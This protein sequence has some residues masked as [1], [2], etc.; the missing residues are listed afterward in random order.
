MTKPIVNMEYVACNLCG[1]DDAVIVYRKR[2]KT[3]P[4]VYDI[5]K[6]RNC[7]LIYV[8]PRLTPTYKEKLYTDDYYEGKGFDAHFIG[9]TKKKEE[10]A[11]LLVRC[12]KDAIL[13]DK[14]KPRLLEVG[15]GMD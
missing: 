5:V 2:G 1:M 6:C 8:N 9:S 12:I 3:I 15:G 4:I 14:E 7:G 13:K 10:D 11:K